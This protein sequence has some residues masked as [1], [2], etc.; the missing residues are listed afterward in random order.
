MIHSKKSDIV[1]VITSVGTEIIPDQK[2]MDKLDMY[3]QISVPGYSDILDEYKKD[4]RRSKHSEARSLWNP[5]CR[6]LSSEERN[7]IQGLQ[8]MINVYKFIFVRDPKTNRSIRYSSKDKMSHKDSS[9]VFLKENSEQFLPIFGSIVTIF[10]HTFVETTY[11]VELIL[12]NQ[13]SYDIDCKMWHASI[14]FQKDKQVFPLSQISYPLT[15]A[16][17]QEQYWFLNYCAL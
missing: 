15:V 6:N 4:L 16:Y 9:F 10:S 13:A 2:I 11:W 1:S 7:L 12:F 3:Y 5:P 8:R 17:E 14:D